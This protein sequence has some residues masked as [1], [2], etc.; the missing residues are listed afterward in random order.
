[1]EH[2]LERE[3]AQWVHHEGSIQW[4]YHGAAYGHR[5]SAK[6]GYWLYDWS[7]FAERCHWYGKYKSLVT[8]VSNITAVLPRTALFA[9]SAFQTGPLSRFLTPLYT[10]HWTVL[11]QSEY[12][13]LVRVVSTPHSRGR[14]RLDIPGGLQVE[15]FK[16]EQKRFS[17]KKKKCNLFYFI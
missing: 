17:F 5:L 4:T 13:G 11:T 2:W 15:S 3:I 1:M 9:L 7:V 8:R 10:T 6:V 12:S 14:H 16:L